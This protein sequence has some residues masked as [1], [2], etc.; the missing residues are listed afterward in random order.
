MSGH[1]RS[2]AAYPDVNAQNRYA[3]AQITHRD[4]IRPPEINVE[5]A[6]AVGR[7]S[8]S[9]ASGLLPPS[10]IAI[11]SVVAPTCEREIFLDRE[12]GSRSAR[13]PL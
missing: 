4:G 7:G 9:G 10:I 3:V 8:V 13:W 12:G 6:Q 1:I 5:D 2:A 11:T